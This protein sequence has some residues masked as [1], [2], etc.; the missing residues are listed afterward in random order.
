MPLVVALK[1]PANQ[2]QRLVESQI[3]RIG[4]DH[5]RLATEVPQE[6]LLCNALGDPRHDVLLKARPPGRRPRRARET[7]TLAFLGFMQHQRK[8]VP[9]PSQDSAWCGIGSRRLDG[10]LAIKL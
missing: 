1:R 7:T 10:S 8:A 5:R 9:D 4:G 2:G 6:P 3:F